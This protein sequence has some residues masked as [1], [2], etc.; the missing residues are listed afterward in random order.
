MGVNWEKI[1]SFS[2]SPT[3][4]KVSDEIIASPIRIIEVSFTIAEL[5]WSAGLINGA[6]GAK[7]I[8]A[9]TQE[10]TYRQISQSI[11]LFWGLQIGLHWMK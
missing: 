10:C 2:K 3:T 4:A 5:D 8:V 7:I 6:G 9:N 11:P 1:T